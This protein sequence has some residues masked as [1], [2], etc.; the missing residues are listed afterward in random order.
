MNYLA[1]IFLSGEDKAIQ[2]GNFVGDA[3]K[4]SAYHQ[5]P[6][7]FQTGILLHRQ[8][9]AFSDT[10]PMVREAVALGRESL[11]RYS[12]VVMDIFFDHFLAVHFRE[13][14]D[15]SLSLFAYRF[16]WTLLIHYRQLPPRFQG[17]LWHFIMTN[18][19][20]CYASPEGV[21]RSL[22]IMARY[23]GLQVDPSEAIRF[24]Q[25]YHEE[26]LKLFRQFFPDLQAMCQRELVRL[27]TPMLN[28]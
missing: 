24:L 27:T 15:R 23:R 7:G 18:R 20:V 16:Y 6:Q 12:A 11:G 4:G 26:L 22:E 1:H 13:Y 2:I 14:A 5:Y 19:L 25:S 21:R 3:V 9:D 28:S 8:V 10:H 17:F